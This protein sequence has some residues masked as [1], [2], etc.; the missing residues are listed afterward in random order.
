MDNEGK[1]P[2]YMISLYYPSATSD[3]SEIEESGA[4]C[5]EV[6]EFNDIL[7][8][9]GFQLEETPPQD[10]AFADLKGAITSITSFSLG[11]NSTNS[12][13]ASAKKNTKQAA[14]NRALGVVAPSVATPQCPQQLLDAITL[15]EG[16]MSTFS[17]SL[18]TMIPS[19]DSKGNVPL[20]SVEETSSKWPS[21]SAS[22]DAFE[23]SVVNLI[24][25]LQ[26]EDADV[27]T[28]DVKAKAESIV[29]DAYLPSRYKYEDLSSRQASD[30]VARTTAHL[31][32]TSA[33]TV[34]VQ[35]SFPSGT[36][37]NGTKS[38]TLA[39][40]QKI[41]TTSGGFLITEVPATSYSSVT[42]P[43]T[44]GAT[45]TQNV[46]GV[47]NAGMPSLG[48]TALVNV[49]LPIFHDLRW[50]NNSRYGWAVAA[51][52]SYNLSNGKA[53]T[54]K[55]GL[56]AGLSFH[57]HGQFFATP[58]VNIGQYSNWPVGFSQAGQVIPPNVGTPS[59][60]NKWTTRFGFA[61]TYK[62]KDFGESSSPSPIP[63]SSTS[64]TSTTSQQPS[65]KGK[66]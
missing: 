12:V 26:V 35:A 59:G 58:G 20:I 2:S 22:Y 66:T 40:G 15:A 61:V 43:N 10:N 47:N 32:A 8:T 50:L 38:F 37:S 18:T 21:V 54:S 25:A 53:D 39:A 7:Y 41:L 51:G 3:P 1:P 23:G 29:L 5:L 52:P 48:L 49:Y 56:M 30:H 17:G 27:C 4:T 16:L 42:A 31:N 13:A 6:R 34:T 19:P 9:A 33:Y 55:F 36:V 24:S 11:S 65:K 62:I 57:I 60:V 44:T 28:D 45:S 63:S 64:G 14:A 46:L